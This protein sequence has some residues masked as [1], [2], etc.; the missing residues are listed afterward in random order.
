MTKKRIYLNANRVFWRSCVEQEDGTVQTVA[1]D[2]TWQWA[3]SPCCFSDIYDGE[4]YDARLEGEANQEWQP[5]RLIEYPF[6]H[7][8]AQNDEPV[9]FTEQL[10]PVEI[11]K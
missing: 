9:R 5:V 2:E 8:S 4:T 7:I 6:N 3:Q 1:T 10:Q 11:F